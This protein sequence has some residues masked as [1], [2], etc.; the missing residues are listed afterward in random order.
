MINSLCSIRIFAIYICAILLAGCGLSPDFQ[1]SRLQ[2]ASSFDLC[3]AATDPA[4][5]SFGPERARAQAASSLI[6]ERR[7][8][9]DYEQLARIRESEARVAATRANERAAWAAVSAA[10][11]QMMQGASPAPAAPIAGQPGHRMLQ[12]HY[13]QG[14]NRICVY[15]D[16]GSPFILTIS[17]MS[18]CPLRV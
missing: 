11:F 10:G 9:C 17:V 12:R 13:V 4:R 18:L 8:Q 15:S 1:R 2:S 14:T 3:Y 16:F 6:Q 7:I 5:N